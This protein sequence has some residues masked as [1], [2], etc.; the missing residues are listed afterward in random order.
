MGRQRTDTD[1]RAGVG[2]SLGVANGRGVLTLDKRAFLGWLGVESLVLEIP[3]VSPPLPDGA[4]PRQYQRRR[5]RVR[6]ATFQVS[7]RQLERLSELRRDALRECGASQVALTCGDG[8]VTVSGVWGVGEARAGFDYRVRVAAIGGEPRG[9]RVGP[10]RLA[11]LLERPR[12]Y[13]FVPTPAA[14]IAHRV[15]AALLGISGA[16]GGPRP[17]RPANRDRQLKGGSEREEGASGDSAAAQRGGDG[18]AFATGLAEIALDGLDGFLWTLL[19]TAGWRLPRT[20]GVAITSLSVRRG[21]IRAVYTAAA[22][23]KPQARAAPDA[24]TEALAQV[25]SQTRAADAVLLAEGPNAALAAY[26]AARGTAEAATA[27]GRRRDGSPAGAGNGL[28][29]ERVLGLCAAEPALFEHGRKLAATQMTNA[30]NA[31]AALLTL[32]AMDVHEGATAQAASHYQRV[33]KLAEGSGDSEGALRAGLAAARLL[34]LTSPALA[35]EIYERIVARQPEQ[36]EA[37][38]ALVAMYTANASWGP[39]TTFL[40]RRIE[41]IEDPI[42]RVPDWVRLAWVLFEKLGEVE[43]ARTEL[44][45][46]RRIN[47]VHIPALEL[48]AALALAAGARAEAREKLGHVANL[49]QRQGDE[50]AAALA[51]AKSGALWAQEGDLEQAEAA[52][53]EALGLVPDLLAARHGLALV[54][55]RG[56]EHA[57]AAEAW[58][59]LS[60][61]SSASADDRSRYPR[62]HARSRWAAGELAA[63]EQAL[64]VAAAS[65]AATAEHAE[66]AAATAEHAEHAAATAEH[67]KHAAA[68][69]EHAEHA[70]ATAEHAK[71]GG[72][73]RRQPRT[74]DSPARERH[75]SLALTGRLHSALAALQ[76]SQGALEPAAHA[77]AAASDAFA[78]AAD[79][80]YAELAASPDSSPLPTNPAD[81]PAPTSATAPTLPPGEPTPSSSV[82]HAPLGQT[83]V[84]LVWPHE[85]SELGATDAPAGQRYLHRAA[86]LASQQAALLTQLDRAEDASAAR[87][88]ARTLARS[89]IAIATLDTASARISSISGDTEDQ[90]ERLERHLGN[91]LERDPSPRERVDLLL[92]RAELRTQPFIEQPP[93]T[94]AEAP[95]TADPAP[96]TDDD[97]RARL[98]QSLAD[99]DD[100]LAAQPSPIQ[101]AL[102]VTLRA[103]ILRSL[104]DTAGQAQALTERA[105]LVTPPADRAHAEADAAAAWLAAGAVDT[106]MKTAWLALEALNPDRP[107]PNTH[108]LRRVLGEAAWRRQS[109]DKVIEAYTALI[110]Q[111]AA[112][113][114]DHTD[115]AAPDSESNAAS[116]HAP[117]DLVTWAQRLGS[118]HEAVGDYASAAASFEHAVALATRHPD[119]VDAKERF[120]SHRALAR[121]RE[122]AGDLEQAAQH[123]EALARALADQRDAAC[124]PRDIADAWFRAGDLHKRQNQR[125]PARRCFEAALEHAEDHFP[126][127]DALEALERDHRAYDQVA[128]VLE[129]KLALTTAHPARQRAILL[130]LAQLQAE[131]L[132]RPN[133]A[134]ASYQRVLELDPD[135][136]QALTAVAAQTRADS[137]HEAAFDA[138][139]RLSGVLAD[140]RRPPRGATPADDRPAPPDG[141]MAERLR[142]LTVASELV[143]K[144]PKRRSRAYLAA[145]ELRAFLPDHPD[146]QAILRKMTPASSPSPAAATP[147]TPSTSP[148]STPKAS[149]ADAP[150]T[151]APDTDAPDTD[152]PD[153]AASNTEVSDANAARSAPAPAPPSSQDASDAEQTDIEFA[154]VEA[155]PSEPTPTDSA[156]AANPAESLRERVDT[157]LAA[158]DYAA[159]ASALESL[160]RTLPSGD[161]P[162]AARYRIRRA[163]ALLELADLYTDKLGDRAAGRRSL[164]AAADTYGSGARHDATLRILAA[165]AVAEDA[166]DEAASAYEA[167]P[168]AQRTVADRT[169]LAAAYYRIG[170]RDQARA[171]LTELD[172]AGSL[173]DDGALMLFGLNQAE[174]AAREQAARADQAIVSAQMG[175]NTD[176]DTGG[177]EDTDR[178][179][180]A[181]AAG[182]P[183]TPNLGPAPEA[184]EDEATAP[185][186]PEVHTARRRR[187]ARKS[188]EATR[189]GV[190]PPGRSMPLP[191]LRKPRVPGGGDSSSSSQ[192]ELVI[193]AALEHLDRRAP[194]EHRAERHRDD[195][196]AAASEPS[197]THAI[198]TP[199]PRS[200][201]PMGT[202]TAPPPGTPQVPENPPAASGK[203][204]RQSRITQ[205]GLVTPLRAKSS[206]S[207]IT[208]PGVELDIRKLENAAIMTKDPARAAELLAQSLTLR[209][210]RLSRHHRPLDD[211]AR[212]VLS[213]LRDVTRRSGKHRLL[214]HGLEAAA[215]VGGDPTTSAS[216]LCEAAA[217]LE[218]PLG[219]DAHATRLLTRALEIAPADA[220]ALERLAQLLRKRGDAARLAEIYKLHLGALDGRARARPLY[221]LGCLYRDLLEDPRR[222]GSCFARAHESDPD[223]QT[224]W[225]PLANAR[226]A[227]GDSVSARRLYDL[228]LER[229]RPDPD[230]RDWILSRLAAIDDDGS[231]RATSTDQ[232]AHDPHRGRRR[233]GPTVFHAG[234]GALQGPADSRVEEALQRAAG[235]ESRG[236]PDAAIVHYRVAAEHDPDDQRPLDALERLHRQR[237]E[238]QLYA[239]LLVR[240]LETTPTLSARAQL[241]ARRGRLARDELGREADAYRCYRQAHEAAP[242]DPDIAHALR[243][244]AME[245]GEWTMA[246]DLLRREIDAAPTTTA[247]GRL[248]MDLAVLYD[249]KLLN[250]DKARQHYE[251]ALALAPALPGAPRPLARLYELAGAHAEAA[252]MNEL[253]AQ[254]ARDD[255]QRSRLLYRA[256]VSAERAADIPAA[257]RLYHLAALAAPAGDDASA[258]YRALV[259]LD[260]HSET[261]KRELLELELREASEV[262]QR[263]DILHQLLA[264]AESSGDRDAAD[265]HARALLNM[266]GADLSAYLVL[267]SQAEATQDWRALASLL[268]ARAVSLTDRD[269]RAAVYYDLGR[270][271]HTH[272]GDPEAA[273]RSFER[274][275][276]ADPSHPA[277]LEALAELAYE[278]R[279][280]PQ[281]RQ[282]YARIK[283]DACA[284]P[285]EEIA[286]RRG[287]IAETLG[288]QREALEAYSLAVELLPSHR[289]ALDSLLRL[290]LSAGELEPA[291]AA[292][293][294][295]IDLMPPDDIAAISQARL[296]L[297]A[298]C[299][300]AGDT[301]TAIEYAEMVVAEHPGSQVALNTLARLSEQ[302]GDLHEAA[303]ALKRL[304]GLAITPSERAALLHRLGELYQNRLDDP[305]QAADAYLK[306]IDLDPQHVPTLRRLLDHYWREGDIAEL[307]DI[308]RSLAELAALLDNETNLTTLTRC[309]IAAAV[310]DDEV[311]ARRLV[312]RIGGALAPILAQALAELVRRGDQAS[313][314]TT[315]TRAVNRI[316]ALAPGLSTVSVANALAAEGTE[317]RPLAQ[318]LQRTARTT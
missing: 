194:L 208:Y 97:T 224:V 67:A 71:H 225:L 262:E 217:L 140:E 39:L 115:N 7:Q 267:K 314:I 120:E 263:I 161:G 95:P 148:I 252:S 207:T 116:P 279:D 107:D 244:L 94:D 259:R 52:Y 192:I 17:E 47:P 247:A 92:A 301:A 43:A 3:G 304:I 175:E 41:A 298:L 282:L 218:G 19:P 85:D 169:H 33:S 145:V 299:E 45:Q 166:D 180:A 205:P 173:S 14:V 118:A 258:S 158:A 126:T 216:L 150:D 241:L 144:H 122:H 243:Q 274:A 6:A 86:Q 250:A 213:R 248:E 106:A 87:L 230:T 203:R 177:E 239:D 25:I 61:R 283:P 40:R 31:Q 104:G 255:S 312:Q 100:A 121:S 111:S 131:K 165:Q 168:I 64:A 114:S 229:Q 12:V 302:H 223:F 210:S 193:P 191:L 57:A 300:R 98:R 156:A 2:F 84:A 48:E 9:P 264:R 79:A 124:D 308:A 176:D 234:G 76:R 24:A 73:A 297:A 133:A 237:G 164:R 132:Q 195:P 269:D 54:A 315:L 143:G 253:A 68:T 123:Y 310:L 163:E 13:G 152:A 78:R 103:D 238:I 82:E 221:E 313:D 170:R 309:L 22:E 240:L 235:L 49:W 231:R 179:E 74:A 268:N 160:L 5:S 89:L 305:E 136:R 59:A 288:H 62:E 294:A 151:D 55:S 317:A 272:L 58:R 296:E 142:A 157:A 215:A 138:Y 119:H 290:A 162:T 196:A 202:P 280:W 146:L 102:A 69:A 88:R 149:N 77:L 139:V 251:N 201:L 96:I 182:Q 34:A 295:L 65:A 147:K 316:A 4:S 220:A 127:L 56:G 44:Q 219:D 110:T 32:A 134:F 171:L 135:N 260:D 27:A 35:Q 289:L 21:G 141:L 276:A 303:R 222:A 265:R 91:Q 292:S 1:T 291:I 226:L 233:R 214:V 270:L 227:E 286:Y 112:N 181:P 198:P 261:A 184:V 125:E 26:R 167:I 172:D 128:A 275:L 187:R 37:G 271:Y 284:T 99:I 206:R 306:A 108:R 46:A 10:D 293:R 51:L 63:A 249:E 153:T 60:E 16:E 211:D 18:F 70:A 117:S 8:A 254:H 42:R 232:P 155:A 36:R 257:R 66:H 29:D 190:V 80:F 185:V 72:G 23:A 30:S 209:T 189:I 242:D 83:N 90:P 246:A 204:R 20:E 174:R 200:T 38:E 188:F 15:T 212:A 178:V 81:S 109:W 318:A 236:R 287:V 113:L 137:N 281:A 228:V 256:A 130:R 75:P 53:R 273:A 101:R 154:D 183:P 186:A 199:E 245:R 266:D 105:A 307:A 93:S 278:Q 28:I 50:A 129:R 277:A 285:S 159:A 197:A 311:L 11:L